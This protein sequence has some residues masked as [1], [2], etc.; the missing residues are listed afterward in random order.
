VS[1]LSVLA[2][3][4]EEPALDELRYLLRSSPHVSGLSLAQSA[5]EALMRLQEG[6][7]DVVLLDIRMPGLDG[8]DLA[9]VLARFS[10]PP[11]VIFVTAHEAHALEAFDVGAAGYLLK[12]INGERLEQLLARLRRPQ[13]DESPAHF[14]GYAVESGGRTKIVSRADICWVE[15]AGDY[16]RLHLRDAT[17]YLLRAAISALEDEWSDHG[18][19]RVHRSFLVSLRD[20]QEFRTE[21]ARTT[22][23]VCGHELPVSRRNLRDVRDRLVRHARPGA[24]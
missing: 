20:I 13:S 6:G 3:D 21:G 16:V 10:A 14:D 5:T 2:V 12:P 18:F 1:G 9:R 19:A 11:A 4:D 23:T 7:I 24:R 22:V 15:S 8:M 17:S